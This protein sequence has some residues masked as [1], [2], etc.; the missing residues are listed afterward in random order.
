M[1]LI[2]IQFYRPAAITYCSLLDYCDFQ[3]SGIMFLILFLIGKPHM[4]KKVHMA[5]NHHLEVKN[6]ELS[7]FLS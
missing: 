1:K 5:P 7:S 2:L 3:K 6:W 4:G